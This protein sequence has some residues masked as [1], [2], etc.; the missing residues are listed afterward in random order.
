MIKYILSNYR[1]RELLTVFSDEYIWSILKHI[2]G[3]EGV[4]LRYLYLKIFA[5]RV[6]GFVYIQRDVHIMNSFGLSFGKDIYI[7][8]GCHIDAYGSIT[9]G[10]RSALGPHVILITNDHGFLTKGTNYKERKWI[11]RPIYIGSQTMIAAKSYI[12][13]GVTIG[14]NVVVAAGSTIF[15]DIPDHAYVSNAKLYSYF[16]VMRHNLTFLRNISL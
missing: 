12:N 3:L 10:D 8:R 16:D 15:C 4:Y 5:K 1:L 7:N 9:I 2:P 11:K 13:P 14:N 6:D